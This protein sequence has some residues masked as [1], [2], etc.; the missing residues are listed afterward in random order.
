[1]FRL[2]IL[3]SFVLSSISLHAQAGLYVGGG[4]NLSFTNYK[5][6]SSIIGRYNETRLGL[7]KKMDR[8]NL[9]HGPAILF[10]VQ[11]GKDSK[12]AA[13]FDFGHY[14]NIV[15]SNYTDANGQLFTTDLQ[16]K[17]DMFSLSFGAFPEVWDKLKFGFGLSL[18][19]G[20][21]QFNLR[22]SEYVYA[23]PET[24]TPIAEY[25]ALG[26]APMMQFFIGLTKNLF[27]HLKPYYNFDV[28]LSDI[29]E[30][31]KKLNPT[32]YLQDRDL[33]Y[34]QRFN[35]FGLYG[36]FAFSF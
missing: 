11:M 5:T 28:T 26:V 20:H 6:V 14:G 24:F 3:I 19:Y 23:N 17:T 33:N 32:T 18:F 31:N 25:S 36:G 8:F 4:Y 34:E 13:N 2:I 15:S 21:Y 1:M 10:G 7:S 29:Y 9:L 12:Y 35:N 22:S 30:L 27:F 16:L